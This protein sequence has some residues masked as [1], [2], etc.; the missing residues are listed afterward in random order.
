MP[1]P[2]RPDPRGGE[3]PLD[4]LLSALADAT[5]RAVIGHF[6]RADRGVATTAELAEELSGD[7]TGVERDRLAARLHHAA[8]PKLDA[9]GVVEYDPTSRTARYRGE[10]LSEPVRRLVA[11]LETVAP[12]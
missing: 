9:A 5:R 6:R 11:N 4:E 10:E 12:A 3:A 7:A 1:E 2:S 8:L